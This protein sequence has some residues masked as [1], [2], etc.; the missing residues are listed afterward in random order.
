MPKIQKRLPKNIPISVDAIMGKNPFTGIL[1][2]LAGAG[3][4]TTIILAHM[5]TNLVDVNAII[6]KEEHVRTKSNF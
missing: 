6:M 4:I 5:T 1:M 3:V 2:N